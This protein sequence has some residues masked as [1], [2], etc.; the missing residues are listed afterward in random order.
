MGRCAAA[1]VGACRRAYWCTVSCFRAQTGAVEFG[2]RVGTTPRPCS[3]LD[4]TPWHTWGD[5][6]SGTATGRTGT[7]AEPVGHP[8][9]AFQGRRSQTVDFQIDL[10]R[11]KAGKS[12]SCI[13]M[14]ELH[15]WQ[16]TCRHFCSCLLFSEVHGRLEQS[17]ILQVN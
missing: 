15:C 6:D 12:S 3:Y 16:P 9:R 1:V 17:M 8:Q 11:L 13:G 4:H 7:G 10:R 5:H 2:D 14:K